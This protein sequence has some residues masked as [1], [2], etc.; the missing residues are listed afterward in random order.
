MSD[1][2]EHGEHEHGSVGRLI[3]IGLAAL[4]PSL[5]STIGWLGMIGMIVGGIVM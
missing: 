4:F 2:N 3:A 1:Y 5:R